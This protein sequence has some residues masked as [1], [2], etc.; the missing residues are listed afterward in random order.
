[1]MEYLQNSKHKGIV[2]KI[3]TNYHKKARGKITANCNIISMK[4]GIIKSELFDETNDLV[5]EVFC[6]WKMKKNDN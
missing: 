4:N 2:T 1:M 5:C 6:M 3:T